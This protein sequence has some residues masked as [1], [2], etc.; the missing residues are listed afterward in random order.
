MRILIFL[1]IV[2]LFGCSEDPLPYVTPRPVTP[3]IY[4]DSLGL[5]MKE[6][7]KTH[8]EDGFMVGIQVIEYTTEVF[9]VDD[10]K[11]NCYNLF[12]KCYL[13]RGVSSGS[14]YIIYP[15]YKVDK[16]IYEHYQKTIVGY[17]FNGHIERSKCYGV[18]YEVRHEGLTVVR[19]YLTWPE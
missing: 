17:L 12:L 8:R 7:L 19:E 1:S 4:P 16:I 6:V 11:V 9:G 10:N 15:V 5:R 18:Y 2:F 3:L 13:P 14:Q